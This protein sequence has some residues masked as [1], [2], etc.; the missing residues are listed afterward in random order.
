MLKNLHIDSR[1]TFILK[2]LLFAYLITAGLLLLLALLLYRFELSEQIVSIAIIVIYV[3][4]TFLAGFVAGKKMGARKFLWGLMMGALYFVVLI[5]VSLAVNKGLGG[6]T[7][8]F[9]TVML[10]CT[11]SGMLGGMVS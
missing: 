4:V 7:N 1:V 9:V 3:A 11:G 10:L 8:D 2:C 6:V 5:L